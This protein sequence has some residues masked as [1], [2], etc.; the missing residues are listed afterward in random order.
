MAK[1]GNND[2]QPG[3]VK[4]K[5]VAKS[6]ELIPVYGLP[7]LPNTAIYGLIDGLDIVHGSAVVNGWAFNAKQADQ[8]VEVLVMDGKKLLGRRFANL[9]RP[10]VFAAGAPCVEVGF[11]VF[12]KT[13]GDETE[14]TI[15]IVAD[16]EVQRLGVLKV[17]KK[18]P[19]QEL[20][21]EDII[22]TFR[23]LF[24]RDP[25]DDNAINH[26]LASHSTRASL[27]N[28]LFT[29]PEFFEKNGDIIKLLHQM[30]FR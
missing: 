13:S 25:E 10:D 6:N 20:V 30:K 3:S 29:S 28:A 27:F 2:F 18:L 19:T 26:Q 21:K 12:L 22:S 17:R 15:I 4:S 5:I 14:L 24:H 23:L 16:K 1:K 11:Q 9:H 7:N 8:P